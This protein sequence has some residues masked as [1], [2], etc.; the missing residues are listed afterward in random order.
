MDI[1]GDTARRI[2]AVVALRCYDRRKLELPLKIYPVV[3]LITHREGSEF[4]GRGSFLAV[5]IGMS[6]ALMDCEFVEFLK[7]RLQF[8]ICM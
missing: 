4:I 6:N 1:R 5:K 2:R 8:F 7:Y 3:G